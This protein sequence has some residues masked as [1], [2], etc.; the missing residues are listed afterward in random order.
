MH[1]GTSLDYVSDISLYVHVWII[2]CVV[3]IISCTL[4][5]GVNVV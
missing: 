5:V 2:S 1:V 3:K 4:Y